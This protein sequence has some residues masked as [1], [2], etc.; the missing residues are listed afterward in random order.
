MGTY[1]GG[2]TPQVDVVPGLGVPISHLDL[3]V[4]RTIDRVGGAAKKEGSGTVADVTLQKPPRGGLRLRLGAR[5]G[6]NL[7][8]EERYWGRDAIKRNRRRK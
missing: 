8:M 7:S 5:P 1:H 6:I 2:I 4:S 3:F